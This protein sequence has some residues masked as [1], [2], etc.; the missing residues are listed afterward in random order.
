MKTFVFINICLFLGVLFYTYITNTNTVN[1]KDDNF[2][3]L[4]LRFFNSI[5]SPV[6]Q[7]GINITNYTTLLTYDNII[8][9]KY[10]IPIQINNTNKDITYFSLNTTNKNIHISY[11]IN[12]NP[13]L[14][15]H[16]TNINILGIT[17][18]INENMLSIIYNNNTIHYHI[19]NYTNNTETEID[20][21]IDIPTNKKIKFSK[22][23]TNKNSIISLDDNNTFY[24]NIFT[25]QKTI[26]SYIF[27][28]FITAN[29]CISFKIT[30]YDSFT[31]IN[32]DYLILSIIYYCVDLDNISLK[33]STIFLKLTGLN[34]YKH[35]IKEIYTL[36]IT[37]YDH[38]GQINPLLDGLLSLTKTSEIFYNKYNSLFFVNLNNTYQLVQEF[39]YY[40]KE[41]VTYYNVYTFK[42]A[43]SIECIDKHTFIID[44][45]IV[46]I[47]LDSKSNGDMIITYFDLG[48]FK[49]YKVVFPNKIRVNNIDIAAVQD[50]NNMNEDMKSMIEIKQLKDKNILLYNN[51]CISNSNSRMLLIRLN[52]LLVSNEQGIMSNIKNN[53]STLINV[54][55]AIAFGMLIP[56]F[57]N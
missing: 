54:M 30:D 55:Y 25:D 29:T 14:V 21:Y 6:N 48:L 23:K 47:C 56:Y 8:Q 33:Y 3:K 37:K 31:T 20:S 13:I 22:I 36:E 53:F 4:F 46:V 18:N 35:K 1:N 7:K 26:F 10:F 38:I 32:N 27:H 40:E 17:S 15:T 39:K 9:S 16:K 45:N 24:I 28:N 41:E 11:N 50:M 57:F 52:D 51:K 34:K 19:I 44:S 42:N 12:N 49:K 2:S 5:L 43:T